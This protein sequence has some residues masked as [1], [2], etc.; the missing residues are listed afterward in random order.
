MVPMTSMAALVTS[1]ELRNLEMRR[2]DM[3]WLITT[4]SCLLLGLAIAL[5]GAMLT[6][7]L[8]LMAQ[9]APV[10]AP[11]V[12]QTKPTVVDAAVAQ[13]TT[14]HFTARGTNAPFKVTR[15][16]VV[17]EYALSH[18]LWGEAGGQALLRSRNGQWKVTNSGGGAMNVQTLQGLGV[19]P[20]VAI[21]LLKR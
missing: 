18:W 13:A 17:G 21:Q 16:K 15:T 11:K 8:P 10:S 3:K 2:N 9:Q 1:I 14:Q 19:P 6:P 4:V 12:K 7:Q 20:D 5:G